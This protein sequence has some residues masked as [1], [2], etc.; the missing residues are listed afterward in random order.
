[1]FPKEPKRWH[2]FAA[3]GIGVG[4]ALLWALASWLVR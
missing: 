2:P 3:F 4:L 1:M